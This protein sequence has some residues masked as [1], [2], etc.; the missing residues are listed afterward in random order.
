MSDNDKQ[1]ELAATQPAVP[2]ETSDDA[3]QPATPEVSELAEAVDLATVAE[4]VGVVG[5]VEVAEEVAAEPA[6]ELPPQLPGATLA[7]RREEM[8]LSIDEVS[9]RLKLAP[10]QILAL[11]SDDFAQL[12][13]LATVRGFIRSYAKLLE[14]P[15]EPLI[16]MLVAE[17]DPAV[18]AVVARRPLPSPGFSGRRYSPPTRHRSSARRLTGIA[19]VFF[20]F[21][22][23]LAFIAYRNDWIQVPG[24]DLGASQPAI[25]PASSGAEPATPDVAAS[26]A[27]ANPTEAGATAAVASAASALQLKASQDSWVEVI[28]VDGERKMLSKL[29]KAGTTELVEITEPVVLVVGNAAGIEAV[30]RGQS[31]NLKAATR[32]NVAK[33]SLK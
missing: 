8:R 32:D 20:V 2:A 5:L 15:P 26:P 33:L 16:A 19:V 1:Q 22:G 4:V 30:L 12:P 28:A 14:L 24:F 11:E 13:G 10:R 6:P 7:A 27:A 21:V 29:M 17:R 9:A 25:A 18:D 23:T 3:V 31:L